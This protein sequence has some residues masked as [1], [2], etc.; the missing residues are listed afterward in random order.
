VGEIRVH[1]CGSEIRGHSEG[2]ARRGLG[3]AGVGEI[4]VHPRAYAV[5]AT[6]A[7]EG[8]QR[9]GAPRRCGGG[10]EQNCGGG[11]VCVAAG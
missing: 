1:T 11:A 10:V 8:G 5:L 3:A 7:C 2:R 4:C 9:R 6:R